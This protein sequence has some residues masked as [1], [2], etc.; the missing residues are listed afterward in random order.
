MYHG[1]RAVHHIARGGMLTDEDIRT[2]AA[3]VDWLRRNPHGKRIE[4]VP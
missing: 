3:L 1:K 2:E 4:T